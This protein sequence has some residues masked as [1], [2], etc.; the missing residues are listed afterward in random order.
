M[1]AYLLSGGIFGLSSGL[2]PG[3]LLTLVIAETMRGGLRSGIQVSVAPLITDLPIVMLTL[4][5]IARLSGFHIVLGVISLFGACFVAYLGYESLRTE[6]VPS[7]D[8]CT[9]IRSLRKGIITN[10][11]NPHPYLFWFT[12][13]SPMIVQAY[14][15]SLLASVVFVG[16]FYALLVGSKVLLAFLISSSR[17]LVVGNVYRY[18]MKFLGIVLLIFAVIVLREGLVF[19]GLL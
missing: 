10:F 7:A 15:K 3:P 19:L 14:E 5:V 9:D 1:V 11:L 18:T 12:V 6:E 16:S 8:A 2:A 4:F 17:F 13:G